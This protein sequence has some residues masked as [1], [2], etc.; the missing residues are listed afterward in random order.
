M[1]Y[2]TEQLTSFAARHRTVCLLALFL[3]GLLAGIS[4]L[5]VHFT[6][7]VSRM[8]PDSQDAGVTFRLLNETRLGNTVQLEFIASGNI[9]EHEKYLDSAAEKIRKL[10]GINNLVFRYRTG[11]LSLRRS[12]DDKP[13]TVDTVMELKVRDAMPLWLTKILDECGAYPRGFSKVGTAFMLTLK[14]R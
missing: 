10:P 6:N 14:G 7:D 11:D 3:L 4:L 13:V 1:K 5:R 2:P 12:E 8:F 9:A